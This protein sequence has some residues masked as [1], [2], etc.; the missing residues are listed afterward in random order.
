MALRGT[1][2]GHFGLFSALVAKWLSERL[3]GPFQLVLGSGVQMVLGEA[4]GCHFSLFWALL[5]KW[6][7]QRLASH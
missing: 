6:L 5:D 4:M 2:G 3:W 7:L 1:L